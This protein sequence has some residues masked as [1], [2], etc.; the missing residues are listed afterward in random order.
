MQARAEDGM[1]KPNEFEQ[2]V[3]DVVLVELRRAMRKKCQLTVI[4][5]PWWDA[6]GAYIFAAPN[7]GGLSYTIEKSKA[8]RRA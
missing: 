3:L 2:R 7:A 8:R 6:G 5:D 4:I 1:K